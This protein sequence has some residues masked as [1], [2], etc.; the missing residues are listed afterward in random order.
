MFQ[1]AGKQLEQ[2]GLAWHRGDNRGCADAYRNAYEECIK[3]YRL[4]TSSSAKKWEYEYCCISG[5]TSLLREK[6]IQP[7]DSDIAFLKT[8][9][10]NTSNPIGSAQAYLT[11]GLV[12]WD[13]GLREKAARQYRR[14]LEVSC[15]ATKEQ[16]Q[17]QE[18]MPIGGAYRMQVIEP[19]LNDITRTLRQNLA[20]LENGKTPSAMYDNPASTVSGKVMSYPVKP[21]EGGVEGA[22]SVTNVSGSCCNCCGAVPASRLT[23]ATE[24]ETGIETETNGEKK[25]C[26]AL[27][28]CQRCHRAW[29]CS[30]ECQVNGWKAHKAQ[31]RPRYAFMP[32]D[33]ATLC[34]LNSQPELNGTLVTV[35]GRDERVMSDDLSLQ[36]WQVTPVGQKSII[37]TANKLDRCN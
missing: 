32:G 37:V 1:A 34:N 30:K 26:E 4:Q 8:I 35:L 5:F 14:G 23:D 28:M 36:K 21:G 27:K 19:L 18:M 7:T 24:A 31:C 13:K 16:R 33:M 2:A 29:Y 3:S 22:P 6:E 10:L 9:G 12:Y 15:N 17:R 25:V 11:R 20:V